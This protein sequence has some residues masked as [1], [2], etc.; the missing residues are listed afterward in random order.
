[1]SMD[2]KRDESDPDNSTPTEGSRRQ[3]WYRVDDFLAMGLGAAIIL[4][5]AACS[6]LSR[7]SDL[8]QL[9][10]QYRATKA[11]IVQ[12]D[13]NAEGFSADR[14]LLVKQQGDLESRMASMPLKGWVARPGE[15]KD[16]PRSAFFKNKQSILPSLFATFIV[17]LV[18]F[19]TIAM[20]Q[21]RSAWKFAL[22][23]YGVF[24]L[25][26]VSYLLAGQEFVKH[27]NLEYALWAVLLGLLISN[28]IGTP[29]WL[30]AATNTEFYIKTGLVLLGAE[31][32]FNK[33]LALGLP[34][35]FVAWVVTPIVLVTTYLFG[36]YVLKIPSKSLNMVIS[37]DM[38]VCGV[39]AAVATAAACR[40]KKEEL[41]LAI[42][43]SLIF[44]VVMMVVQPFIV[45]A[46]GMGEVIGGAWMG[47]T[48]DSTGAVA[49]AGELVGS[50]AKDVA[51]TVKMIQ[52]ILI[53]VVAFAVA[54]Y[55]VSFVEPSDDG[56]RPSV[57]E[58]W[59]R[60]PKFTLGFL[61][62]SLI[63]SFVQTQGIEGKM[64]VSSIVDGTTKSVR[65]WMFCLAFVS[66]GLESNFREYRKMLAS[67][68]PVILYVCGQTLNLILSFL[69]AWLMFSK[70]FPNAASEL[71][72]K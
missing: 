1:M 10:E 53:G 32:L 8:P 14:K 15:W 48:I 24:G 35:V 55:W 58:I 6:I 16:D 56:K 47:G 19:A 21:G 69:M 30:S 60:F 31:V 28:T 39:S 37:A 40:A 18:F 13:P 45:R 38:S 59:N 11:Q 26:L 72:G 9:S 29:K 44:T 3:P 7:P 52:N 65:E 43:L 33:L 50:V 25:S 42:G 61:A 12:L 57:M 54:V 51:A 66:I 49:A 46:S 5:A 64:L 36:Q 71:L 34:G 70:I 17:L 23:F 20:I 27:Y 41:S 63:L 4:I 2:T 67:G 22:G 62:V 68:K